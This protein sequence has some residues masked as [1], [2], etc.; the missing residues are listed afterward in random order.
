MLVYA[1]DNARDALRARPAL[2][3][4]ATTKLVGELFPEE[5]LEPLEH[6]G[7]LSYTSP[8]DGEVHIGCFPGVAVV[9]AKEFGEIA[10]P[11][12]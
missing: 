7:D 11:V 6:D 2:D 10:A 9:A 1:D 8:P 5:K 4:E 12:Y 3:R